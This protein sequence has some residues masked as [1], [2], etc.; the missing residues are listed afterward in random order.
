MG[1]ARFVDAS[2]S[3]L[4]DTADVLVCPVNAVPGVMGAGLALAFARRW[5][6]LRRRHAG[7]ARDGRLAPGCAP[8]VGEVGQRFCLFPT[9]RHWRMASRLDDIQASL[10]ALVAE[11]AAASAIR[12]SR[13]IASIAIPALGCGLGVLDWADVKPIV[14]ERLARVD[15]EVRLYAPQE[16]GRA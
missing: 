1:S 15:I 10:D 3:I 6:G 5:P 4:D 11:L 9:K 16:A 7:L 13:P 2:G 8:I 14:V 12:N